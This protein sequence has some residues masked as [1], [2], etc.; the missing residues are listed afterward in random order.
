M[1]SRR[2]ALAAAVL[3]ALS[4][5]ALWLVRSRGAKRPP[6]SVLLVTIDTLRAD[7]LGAYGGPAGLTPALDALAARGLVFE[8]ALASVPLTLPSHAT[9][10]TGLEP[11]RHGVH[12]NGSAVVPAELETLATRLRANGYATGAFVGAYVLDR[13]FGLARG[14]DHYDDRIERVAEGKSVLESERR[15]EDVVAAASAWVR[16]Q[17]GPFFA[18]VHLY[19]PH[20]PYDPTA[21]VP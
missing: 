2:L 13:R 1:R 14:F 3:L 16:S 18:W 8:E 21:P 4:L 11:T 9:M 17:P 5:A 15:G 20:A 7:R 12:V 10:L 6:A 19:D